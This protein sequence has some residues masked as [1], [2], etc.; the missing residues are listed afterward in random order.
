MGLPPGSVIALC[1]HFRNGGDKME[2]GEG[3]EAAHRIVIEVRARWMS[4][5]SLSVYRARIITEP[6]SATDLY[7][8]GGVPVHGPVLDVFVLPALDLIDCPNPPLMWRCGLLFPRASGE[9][10]CVAWSKD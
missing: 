8:P 6:I 5:S 10:R 2:A 4:R 1:S 9:V 3:F 7:G